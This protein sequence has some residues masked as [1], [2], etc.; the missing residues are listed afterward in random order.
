MNDIYLCRS[1]IG[2]VLDICFVQVLFWSVGHLLEEVQPR[3]P[4]LP[5]HFYFCRSSSDTTNT[6]SCTIFFS[7]DPFVLPYTR[8]H[9]ELSL[10][11]YLPQARAVHPPHACRLHSAHPR[12]LTCYRLNCCTNKVSF[13]LHH[14][15]LFRVALYSRTSLCFCEQSRSTSFATTST[16]QAP[17]SFPLDYRQLQPF[18]I[19]RSILPRARWCT[20]AQS[21]QTN[22]GIQTL[23][24][25]SAREAHDMYF[26]LTGNILG[27]VWTKC[28]L[29]RA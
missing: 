1:V 2:F 24:Q 20:H 21:Q 5:S 27:K 17:T 23:C 14:T 19:I 26:L 3:A 12:D 25:T 10:L 9:I 13:H 11:R 16:K 4:H 18:A 22:G 7:P 8:F 15:T 28:G 29:T 6:F